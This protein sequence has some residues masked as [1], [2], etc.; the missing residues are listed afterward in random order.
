MNKFTSEK[1]FTS[2]E[3]VTIKTGLI[4]DLKSGSVARP[5]FYISPAITY[6]PSG[7]CRYVPN[8]AVLKISVSGGGNS[9]SDIS[10][11]VV[12]TTFLG[13]LSSSAQITTIII[14]I[15][16]ILISRFPQKESLLLLI[17]GQL[18]IAFRNTTINIQPT[19]HR[20]KER[21]ENVRGG[22]VVFTLPV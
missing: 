16:G 15:Y 12:Y 20:K 5:T 1:N 8:L 21:K 14:Y 3:Q 17:S 6:S 9:P 22:G 7:G 18:P 10:C 2:K 4:I 19:K 11:L 13:D